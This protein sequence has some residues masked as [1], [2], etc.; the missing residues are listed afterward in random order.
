M[1]HAQRIYLQLRKQIFD[2]LDASVIESLPRLELE[3]Q[4]A[5]AVDMLVSRD[6]LSIS[7]LAK[8]E[9]VTSMVHELVGLGPLQVLMDDDSITDIM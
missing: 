7:S 8:S 3:A 1:E 6:Q 5:S 4:L 9:Y 2:A